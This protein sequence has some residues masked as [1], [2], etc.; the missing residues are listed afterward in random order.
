LQVILVIAGSTW[1]LQR[2]HAETIGMFTGSWPM[3]SSEVAYKD[4][5]AINDLFVS[6]ESN[7]QNS[8]SFNGAISNY[9]EGGSGPCS[10]FDRIC[11]TWSGTL[12]G[13]SVAF[14]GSDGSVEYTFTGTIT[15]GSFSGYYACSNEELSV[16]S[17]NNDASFSFTSRWTNGWVSEGTVN[18]KSCVIA[19][20]GPFTGGT[21]SMTTT[22]GPEPSSMTLLCSG[23]VAVAIFLRRRTKRL[24]GQARQHLHTASFIRRRTE[25]QPALSSYRTK[26]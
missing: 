6:F 26:T 10:I 5:Q 8:F 13:G 14:V 1:G 23:I 20:C 24:S 4:K 18:V 3:T 2:A 15:G 7:F 21:L 17:D 19:G 9:S 22:V 16:C 12:S 11:E 25:T